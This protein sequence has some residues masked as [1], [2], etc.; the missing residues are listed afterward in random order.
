[1]HTALVVSCI[2]FLIA[3]A[4]GWWANVSRGRLIVKLL[5]ERTDF[6]TEIA[7]YKRK[8]LHL[9]IKAHELGGERVTIEAQRLI[10]RSDNPWYV[11]ILGP[12]GPRK[13]HFREV[14]VSFSDGTPTVV[15]EA[16]SRGNPQL[17]HRYPGVESIQIFSP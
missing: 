2:V 15:L 13:G 12:A 3:A 7:G 9:T 16:E 4:I 11:E 6:T 17:N 10:V 14:G 5:K 8:L 1:M